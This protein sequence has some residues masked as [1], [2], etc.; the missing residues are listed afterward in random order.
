[1]ACPT[2]S[3]VTHIQDENLADVPSSL[4]EELAKL[5]SQRMPPGVL[6]HWY[7]LIKGQGELHFILTSVLVED[8][9][10]QL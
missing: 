9:I 5:A 4:K 8:L 1:M 7:Q 2:T 6:L 10:N 3:L